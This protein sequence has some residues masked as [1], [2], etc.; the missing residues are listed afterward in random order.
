[1]GKKSL[2]LKTSFLLGAVLLLTAWPVLTGGGGTARAETA[3]GGLLGIIKAERS[4]ARLPGVRV[5]AVNRET[6]QSWETVSDNFGFYG[7]PVVPG[8]YDLSFHHPDFLT[9]V[10]GPVAVRDNSAPSVDPVLWDLDEPGSTALVGHIFWPNQ[11]PAARFTVRLRNAAGELL[12]Q[13]PTDDLGAFSF[14]LGR[15]NLSL[16][17]E[18]FN[19]DGNY[20]GSIP[21][22]TLDRTVRVLATIAGGFRNYFEDR[23]PWY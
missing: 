12:D 2:L 5:V 22:E 16:V 3:P 10:E 4:F 23:G 11:A 6:G 13:V 9:H 20:D 7:L 21:V 8:I 14:Q 1:M 17:L 15:G 19:Q 18:F